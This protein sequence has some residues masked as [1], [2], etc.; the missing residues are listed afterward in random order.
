MDHAPSNA[1]LKH[2]K[3]KGW[4]FRLLKETHV[5]LVDFKRGMCSCRPQDNSKDNK[6]SEPSSSSSAVWT[7]F[8]AAVMA[9]RSSDLKLPKHIMA[10]LPGG[11]FLAAFMAGVR[12]A[13]R[14][15]AAGKS[16]DTAA[17]VAAR[18][19]AAAAAAK[20]ER[21]AQLVLK[22]T[23]PIVIPGELVGRVL[24]KRGKNIEGFARVNHLHV[25]LEPEACEECRRRGET[26]VCP[27]AKRAIKS[28]LLTRKEP[29]SISDDVVTQLKTLLKSFAYKAR[30]SLE[31]S[32]RRAEER[33][34][35]VASPS[36]LR[37][38]SIGSSATPK[39]LSYEAFTRSLPSHDARRR[40]T[41]AVR[42]Q[43]IDKALRKCRHCGALSGDTAACD[44][45]PAAKCT[46][47][48]GFPRGGRHAST[49]S[50]CG[51]PVAY[52]LAG[53]PDAHDGGCTTGR[54]DFH[55]VHLH[56]KLRI[57]CKV[58]STHTDRSSRTKRSQKARIVI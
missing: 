52:N 46:F 41:K 24:G 43:V 34:H 28:V 8:A 58:V 51:Y 9:K 40:A 50:C 37:T 18:A 11:R 20:A 47:H 35:F 53:A 15:A 12:E 19:A 7:E 32:Q 49:W 44:G 26:C 16:G 10:E 3:D 55:T 54:H 39:H 25:K 33:R 45:K 48:D 4:A 42:R 17:I 2:G 23:V 13:E 14:A 27:P 6:D 30:A 56:N 5:A 57:G 36:D 38:A 29:K 1:C 31:D 22:V 21:L